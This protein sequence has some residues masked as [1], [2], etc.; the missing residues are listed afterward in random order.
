MGGAEIAGLGLQVEGCQMR[1][2]VDKVATALQG[3]EYTSSD[4]VTAIDCYE[5]EW[6]ITQVQGKKGKQSKYIVFVVCDFG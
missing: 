5:A 2:N 6:E 3:A 1:D 4:T